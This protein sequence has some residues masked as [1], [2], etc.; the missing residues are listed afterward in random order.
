MQQPFLSAVLERSSSSHNPHLPCFA[1]DLIQL[2][3]G[4]LLHPTDVLH[5]QIN[6]LIKPAKELPVEVCEEPLFLLQKEE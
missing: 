2:S 4:L 1:T 5:S 6:P 3:L